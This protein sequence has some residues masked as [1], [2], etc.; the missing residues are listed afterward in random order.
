[1]EVSAG[2]IIS[3]SKILCMLKGKAGYGYTSD[4]Y[5]FPG[6][7]L[8]PGETAEQALI[9]ELKEE[10]DADVRP[11][12]IEHFHDLTYEYP[13]FT[14]LLHYFIIRDDDF[15]FR[16]LEHKGFRWSNLE[17]LKQMTWLNADAQLIREH[18]D[19]ITL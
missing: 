19:E 4:R 9:R 2:I 6:G 8:E 18:S 5:E 7:K 15:E 12:T 1:M 14:V 17:Q 3:N 16:P 10:L 11:E 13:D